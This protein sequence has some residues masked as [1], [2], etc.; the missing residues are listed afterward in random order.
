[1]PLNELV[2]RARKSIAERGSV[3]EAEFSKLASL[4]RYVD[5]DY[6]E[7]ETFTKIRQAVG[8]AQRPL[9]YLAIPPARF[10]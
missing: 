6:A 10:Q 4:L 5:G 8:G 1:M 3:D 9:F 7:L 2:D